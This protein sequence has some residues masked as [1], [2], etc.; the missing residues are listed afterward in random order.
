M[1]W[2]TNES[3]SAKK[4]THSTET[5]R[6][7]S[8]L[9]VDFSVP[10]LRTITS[11]TGHTIGHT[12]GH[13]ILTCVMLAPVYKRPYHTTPND[14]THPWATPLSNCSITPL[15]SLSTTPTLSLTQLL[16]FLIGL[17]LLNSLQFDLYLTHLASREKGAVPSC[18]KCLPSRQSRR[19]VVRRCPASGGCGSR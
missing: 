14:P 10:T 5:K 6:S 3:Y 1:S 19:S 8:G 18:A 9:I 4:R 12:T 17:V 15:G 2:R 13:S 7:A 11:T 16:S